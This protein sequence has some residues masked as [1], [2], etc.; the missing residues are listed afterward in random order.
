[1][2][3]KFFV[4]LQGVV[5]AIRSIWYHG[6]IFFKC[7]AVCIAY[8]ASVSVGLGSKE[9][10]RNS[11]LL[12]RNW[13]ESQSKKGGWGRGRKETLADKLLDFENLRL[14]ANGARDWLDQSNIIDMCG[15]LDQEG[16]VCLQ[17]F[18]AE[19]GFSRELRQ[20]GGNPV[21]Q[22]R[23]HFG[24]SKCDSA[25]LFSLFSFSDVWSLSCLNSKDFPLFVLS[26]AIIQ[27]RFLPSGVSLKCAFPGVGFVAVDLLILPNVLTCITLG[28]WGFFWWQSCDSHDRD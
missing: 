24:I 20:Y 8:I 12:V 11:I 15:S 5:N 10:P 16:Q 28:P 1:M 2:Y 6:V 7:L 21:V 17:K 26:Q 14:P 3:L 4:L 19:R 13:G 23:W 22:C 25:T 18:L 27:H 9:R